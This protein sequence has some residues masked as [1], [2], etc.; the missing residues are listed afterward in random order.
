MSEG[1][2]L[3]LNGRALLAL[4]QSGLRFLDERVQKYA[5]GVTNELI[6]HW[7]HSDRVY[8]AQGMISVQADCT[9]DEALAKMTESAEDSGM[10]LDAIATAIIERR[11]RFAAPG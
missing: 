3:R 1:E 9:V 10:G 7:Q 2:Q 5:M 11:I 4:N 8:Q 6:D